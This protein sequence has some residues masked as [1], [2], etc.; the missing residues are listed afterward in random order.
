[1]RSK[2]AALRALRQER[3]HTQRSLARGAGISHPRISQLEAESVPIRPTTAR[4]L[5]DALEVAVA[6]ITVTD[7]PHL[8]PPLAVQISGSAP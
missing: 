3:G 8:D 1:V 7:L 5:A 2:P 6:D 4:K